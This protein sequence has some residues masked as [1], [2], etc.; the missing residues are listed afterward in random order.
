M[1]TNLLSWALAGSLLLGA[2]G[3]G[4][5]AGGAD[6]TGGSTPSEAKSCDDVCNALFDKGCFYAGGESDCRR[7][8]TGWEEQYVATGPEYCKAAWADYKACVV[9]EQLTCSDDLNPDWN[10][11]PCRPHWDHFQNYC[12]Q[13]SATPET[14]CIENP[15][16]DAFCEGDAAHP[17]GKVC[18][19]DA[20]AECVVGG[21]NSNADLYCCP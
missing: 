5:G 10:A 12:I 2:C 11:L 18:R 15:G 19:G 20:P 3:G 13:K 17:K 14:E 4:G 1:K 6:G 21:T 9:S 8:C 16:F 7:S